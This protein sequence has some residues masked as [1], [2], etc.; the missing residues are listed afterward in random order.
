MV[1]GG[2]PPGI[3]IDKD[4]VLQVLGKTKGDITKRRRR[5]NK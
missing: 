5:K 3:K 2:L 4:M 1:G